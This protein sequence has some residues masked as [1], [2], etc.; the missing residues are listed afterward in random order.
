[1][2]GPPLPS[3]DLGDDV[4]ARPEAI[5]AEPLRAARHHQRPPADQAGA[6]QWRNRNIVA[7]LTERECVA[8]V[9]KGVR[10]KAAVPRV[11]GELRTVAEVFH[12]LLAEAAN[13]ACI[14]KPGDSTPGAAP[15]CVAVAADERNAP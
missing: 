2:H 4:P 12:A 11:T 7:L 10:G 1:M 15:G 8:R 3:R 9:G 14:S 6:Q 5:D 13:S